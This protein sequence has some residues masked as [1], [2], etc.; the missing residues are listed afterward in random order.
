MAT[1][2]ERKF[3]V[4]D[5][6]FLTA[7][8]GQTLRQ[9]YLS[10]STQATVRIRIA[11][12]KGFLTIK[13]QNSGISRAEFEYPI[14]LDDAEALLALCQSGRI[15]KTRY[16]VSVGEHLWEVDVFAGD[17]A[18]LIVAEIE[19]RYET[20]TFMRPDWLGAEVSDD[21]RYF[22]SQLSQHPYCQWH[23]HQ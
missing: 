13:G 15:D 11:G 22:N 5:S 6:T 17:N 19:L 18:G 16:R 23:D 3:L 8:G 20:E 7:L 1:E 4:R 9:G 10:H 14:P 2:I 21:P 12:D